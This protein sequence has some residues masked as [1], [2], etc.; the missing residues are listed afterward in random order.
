MIGV[1]E[2]KKLVIRFFISLNHWFFTKNRYQQERK[3][4][5]KLI[6]YLV[7]E[8]YTPEEIQKAYYLY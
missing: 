5:L 4:H 1:Q 7:I 8:L 3:V 2:L 6:T